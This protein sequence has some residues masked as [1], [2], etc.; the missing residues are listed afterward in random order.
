MTMGER[1]LENLLLIP[2][3]FEVDIPQHAAEF[4]RWSRLNGVDENIIAIFVGE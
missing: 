1:E 4:G 2:E 3:D